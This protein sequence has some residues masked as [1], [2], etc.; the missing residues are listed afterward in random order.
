MFKRIIARLLIF[1][2]IYG[3]LFQGALHANFTDHYG[4]PA[5]APPNFRRSIS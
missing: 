2:Q 1:L 3:I 4:I 5:T